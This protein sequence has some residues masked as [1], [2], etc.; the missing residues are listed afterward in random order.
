MALDIVQAGALSL[1][2]DL[3]RYGYQDVGVT[4][5]GAM[6]THAFHW[7]NKLLNN[8]ANAAQIEITM[9]PFKGCFKQ[10]TSFA[11]CGAAVVA[12]LNGNKIK[13]WSSWQ[14]KAGDILEI[15]YPKQGLRS[16]LAVS[17]GFSSP[18]TFGSIS[19]VI[20]NKLGGL[21]K[22]GSKLVNGDT[23][24]FIAQ[25]Q[26]YSRKVPQQFIPEYKSIINI[27]VLT[28]YQFDQF[29][30]EAQKTFFNELYTVTSEIDRMGYRLKGKPIEFAEQSFVS[31]GIALG[32]IQIPANGQPIILMR[33]RQTIGGYP[34][35]GCVCNRD[36]NILAQ[37]TPGTKIRF[38][39]QD[40]F[41][42]EAELHQ[43]QHYF[44]KGSKNND[45]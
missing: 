8:S 43:E 32:A 34:K 21:N 5:G 16:Y 7:A 36:L 18:K 37:A 31:E 11:L 12:T 20:R 39:K 24:P 13:P 22:K 14:A 29:S 26:P 38:F 41:E 1:L 30:E 4:P 44:F 15:G 3:G 35:M 2:Q 27:G 42:A 10:S 33:D 45:S 28:T 17:G 40:L 23:L 9:G 19:T 25:V 6:D